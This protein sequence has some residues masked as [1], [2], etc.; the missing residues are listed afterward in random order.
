MPEIY[1]ITKGLT[2]NL[3]GKAERFFGKTIVSELYALKPGDFHGVVPKL[4]VKEGSLVK[5][6][7]PLFVDKA[8]PAI[9]FTSPVSG[10]VCTIN[11]GERRI[12]L[13]VVVKSD[14]TIEYE[15]FRKGNPLEMSAEEIIAELLRCG[16]WPALKQRPYNVVANPDDRPK[17]IFIPA[18]DTS[19]LAPD[20]DFLV[21][22]A[23]SDFQTGVDALSRL[24]TGVV[25][26]NVNSEYPASPAYTQVK[27]AK[28]NYFKGPHP[29]GNAS[30]QIQ[31][32][33][34]INKGDIVWVINPQDVII[35]GRLFNKGIYDASKIIALTGSE[36][37]NPRYYRIVSG[38]SVKS[39]VEGN[40]QKSDHRCISGN[41]ITGTKV[42]H[43]GYLGYYDAQLTV[44]PE[45]KHSEF[46]GW[47]MPGFNKF[48]FYRLF[49]S[50]LNPSKKYILDT[51]LNGG[52][53]AFVITGMYEQVFPFNI[54]PMQLLKA[55]MAEDIDQMERLGIYEVVEEDFAL[56]EFIDASKTEMQVLV[57][58]GMDLMK[59]EMS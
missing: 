21:Q 22:G 24:T 8:N 18:Y 31:R 14:A 5:A 56:C 41:P 38:T 30:V 19:P 9:C 51:N 47:A 53:R 50:W 10:S 46:L 42:K 49:W 7:T 27:N 57:R 43:S 4:E 29:A 11:R 54:Y 12:I 23:E 1:K 6:G 17:S 58:K 39:I 2:I 25:H 36:V 20:Y 45:G 33:D 37:V 26:V 13:E 15:T 35:I 16:I 3:S 59:K 55:I 48:S 44:I 32:I 40:I 52:H 28:T 34:P